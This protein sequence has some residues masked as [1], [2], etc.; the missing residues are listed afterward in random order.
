MLNNN[1]SI[2]QRW[3]RRHNLKMIRKYAKQYRAA[4]IMQKAG[5]KYLLRAAM[6]LLVLR[7]RIIKFYTA[8]LIQ[9]WYRRCLDKKHLAR[10][11]IGRAHLILYQRKIEKSASLV[12]ERAWK[13]WRVRLGLFEARQFRFF[14]E[15]RAQREGILKAVFR[16]QANFRRRK[17]VAGGVFSHHVLVCARNWHLR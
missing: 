15:L 16:L 11:F 7:K 3:Y 1:A 4:G 8:T 5:R 14:Q 2:I 17:G 9:R 12:I 13:A 6:W 10:L